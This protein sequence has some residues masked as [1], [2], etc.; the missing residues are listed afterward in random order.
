[1]YKY[2][3]QLLK[4]RLG[5]A[6]YGELKRCNCFLAGGAITSIF[7]RQEINDF[8]IYFRRAEDAFSFIL[9]NGGWTIMETDKAF[10]IKHKKEML[11]AIFFKY[12]SAAEEIFESFDFTVCMGAYDF[13]S[14]EFVLHEDFLKDNASRRLVFNSKTNF[15]L[16]SALR[17]EKYKGKGYSISKK[18][19]VKILL[20]ISNLKIDS[21]EKLK[22]HVGGMYGDDITHLLNISEEKPFNL[23]EITATM[24]NDIVPDGPSPDPFSLT[25][26][27]FRKLV[28]EK[29]GLKIPCVKIGNRYYAD[30]LGYMVPICEGDIKGN[31]FL[32]E[33][34]N[35]R[36]F[37]MV[38]YKCVKKIGEGTYRSYHDPN[39]EYKLGQMVTTTNKVGL[40]CVDETGIPNCQFRHY[41]GAVMLKLIVFDAADIVSW[42]GSLFEG[43]MQ[44]AKVYVAEEMPVE[45]G[46]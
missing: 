39:F 3:K 34:F 32:D 45:E 15:P 19:F 43:T 22:V 9:D 7:T 28:A 33:T 2:E 27:S 6:L 38:R 8:D 24:D 16:I 31:F 41:T 14:E 20:G 23:E 18:E 1:M 13:Q 17:V 11:Q 30:Y 44:V 46:K 37:P 5:D 40:F 4:E 12:F 35:A 21:Y 25:S 26:S 36:N 42:K 10:T 29:V